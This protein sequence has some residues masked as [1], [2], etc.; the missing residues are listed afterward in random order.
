MNLS[1]FKEI[2][3]QLFLCS[4]VFEEIMSLISAEISM[5]M[6]LSMGAVGH[7]LCGVMVFWIQFSLE[8][9]QLALELE[10]LPHMAWLV[11]ISGAYQSCAHQRSGFRHNH[12]LKRISEEKISCSEGENN[13]NIPIFLLM[14]TLR[15]Q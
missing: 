1:Y 11:Q 15:L 12:K 14:G 3:C 10:N 2:L 8:W 13:T 4:M 7:P 5:L 6:W 9:P